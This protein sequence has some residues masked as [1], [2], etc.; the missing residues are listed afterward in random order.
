MS[1]PFVEFGPGSVFVLDPGGYDKVMKIE[2]FAPT[3]AGVAV[4]RY[5]PGYKIEYALVRRGKEP[6]K[7]LWSIPGGKTEKEDINQFGYIND[8]ELMAIVAAREVSEETGLEINP[9]GLNGPIF[10]SDY[11]KHRVIYFQTFIS[12][13]DPRS[14]AKLTPGE[15]IIDVGWFSKDD[16]FSEKWCRV[17]RP[18]SLAAREI[19]PQLFPI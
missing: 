11:G 16:C 10:G 17:R 12:G 8:R 1:Y 19:L 9:Y 2:D 5:G 6:G 15:G 13:N 4:A 14:I 3:A 18:L 7:G